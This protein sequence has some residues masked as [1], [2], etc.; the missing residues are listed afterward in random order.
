VDGCGKVRLHWRPEAD[1]WA[2]EIARGTGQPREVLEVY[3]CKAC[4]RSP[5]TI[6][7]YWHV[8][9][10]LDEDG[11]AAKAAAK[12]V[13]ADVRSGAVADG[14]TVG[15]MVSPAVMAKLREQ[16]WRRS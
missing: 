1:R 11:R 8:G 13:R 6:Q 4:P 10:P 7:R 3:Q 9:H 15:Q 12:R 2:D 16:D 14:R 5:V